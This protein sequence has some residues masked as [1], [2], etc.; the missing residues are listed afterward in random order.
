MFFIICGVIMPIVF[1]IYNIICYFNK[2][3]IYTINNKKFVINNN[4]FFKIQLILSCINSILI[5][6]IVYEWEKHDSKFLGFL[7]FI[8][9]FWGINYL[10][11]FIAIFKKYAK[12]N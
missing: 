3:V 6:I 8:V 1:I 10:I 4:N 12:I 2:K 11:K 5:S 9:T 7:L